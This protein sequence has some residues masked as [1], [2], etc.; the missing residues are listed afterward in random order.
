M[1]F[2]ERTAKLSGFCFAILKFCI[3]RSVCSSTATRGVCDALPLNIFWS[4]IIRTHLVNIS[5][6]QNAWPQDPDLSEINLNPHVALVVADCVLNI[7]QWRWDSAMVWNRRT[8]PR[9]YILVA[10]NCMSERLAHAPVWDTDNVCSQHLYPSENASL[11]YKKPVEMVYM[12]MWYNLCC[13]GFAWLQLWWRSL[14][15]MCNC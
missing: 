9:H 12:L 5:F 11:R 7:S 14:Q 4:A 1:K 2:C 10:F 6:E 3:A 8:Q 13:R 15:N